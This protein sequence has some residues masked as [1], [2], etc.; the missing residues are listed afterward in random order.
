MSRVVDFKTKWDGE[1]IA[2]GFQIYSSDGVNI[3]TKPLSGN[4][5]ITRVGPATWKRVT[6]LGKSVAVGISYKYEN[7]ERVLEMA[8]I[9]DLSYITV[10]ATKIRNRKVCS[11]QDIAKEAGT[12]SG[13]AYVANIETR[14]V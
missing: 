14:R 4:V 2:K 12:T 13:N 6:N 10:S 7:G 9:N 1:Y 11:T 3:D 8:E 5:S